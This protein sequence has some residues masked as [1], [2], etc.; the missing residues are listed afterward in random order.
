MQNVIL[1]IAGIVILY[2]PP[3]DL[4]GNIQTYI[5]Q[6]DKL[7]VIDNSDNVNHSLV[8]KVKKLNK[9]EYIWNKTNIG[10]AA[11]L[12]IGVQKAIKEGYDYLLTMDQDSEASPFM[13]SNL[14]ECFSYDNKIAAVSPVLKYPLG[15]N[16]DYKNMRPC[17]QVFSAWTS[18]NLVDINIFKI[19]GGYREDFFIDY[20]DH[21]FC[22]RLNKMGY[23]IY[24]CYNTFLTHRLG[25]P[26][27]KN[28]IFRKVYPSNH[29][30]LRHYYR[31]RNRFY[32]KRDYKDIIPG[33]F[34][35]DNKDFWKSVLKAILFEKNKLK[36]IEYFILGYIDYRR[37]KLGKLNRN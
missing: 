16:I 15:K 5:N 29:S 33:F 13:I 32:L 14:L 4:I 12:N 11:A 21:E 17:K 10:I 36:K 2:Y 1:K 20:V 18:G 19:A 34:V 24:I 27:E 6:L 26:E 22:L 31:T 9:A 28:L 23:K 8:E 37:N 7:Y 30:A 35:Q 25:N 3:E